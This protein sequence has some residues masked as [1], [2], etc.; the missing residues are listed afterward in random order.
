M[1]GRVPSR[2]TAPGARRVYR[3]WMAYAVTVLL[4][5]I[6]FGLWQ[7]EPVPIEA[8]AI[9]VFI[10]ALCLFPLALWSARGSRGVPMF[11]LIGI[12]YLLA[13]GMPL[14]THAN[15][16]IILS[17]PV[18]FSWEQTQSTLLLVVV[19]IAC[20]LV[21]YYIV[22]TSVLAR[23]MPRL[24]LP[25]HPGWRA[26]FIP[27]ALVLGLSMFAYN[28]LRPS[29]AADDGSFASFQRVLQ[30]Q[31]Y[32]ALV[33]LAYNVFRNGNRRQALWLYAVAGTA[34]L[35]G[36][37]TGMLENVLVPLLLVFV[38]RWHVRKRLPVSWMA[39]GF[40]LMVLLN[41]VKHE[42]R[43]AAWYSGDQLSAGQKA[44]LWLGLGGQ[45]AQ[46]GTDAE[47]G[48]SQM[49]LSTLSR[50]DLLHQFVRI[51][52]MTP[53]AIPYYD[54]YT[55]QYLLYGWIPRFLWPGKPTAQIAN[56]LLGVDYQF[57]TQEQTS[58]TMIGIGHLPEAYAN[59]GLWGIM[60]SMG[61]QG[62]FL[63]LVDRV[64]NSPAS[65]GGRAIYLTIMV[66]FLNGIGSSTA[67]MFMS[68]LPNVVA[69]ALILRFFAVGWR[70]KTTS[71][72]GFPRGSSR[73]SSSDRSATSSPVIVG[74]RAEP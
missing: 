42:F 25:L 55:Y 5:A 1:S 7:I 47:T 68:I 57:L 40:V 14:Y 33:L 16:I 18:E 34:A 29:D 9:G 15:S 24:D 72:S 38:V 3:V 49:L 46:A 10:A 11:E 35:L 63:A 64:L 60:I 54:G 44:G 32:V 70:S 50:F 69:S 59:F 23:A 41:S 62:A 52:D 20:L 66:F 8:H 53:K 58:G 39:A 31:A 74:E 71:M 27:V 65:D 2:A 67:T 4:Y 21:S 48:A 43:Q 37:M 73:A 36:M 51:T 12:A 17:Q 22:R 28:I 45:A 19:G 13:F 26:R 61:L 6:A 56:T 30:S